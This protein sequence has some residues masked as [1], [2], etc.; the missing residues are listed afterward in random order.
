MYVH[1]FQYHRLLPV[2]AFNPHQ[3]PTVQE[4]SQPHSPKF[5]RFY[6]S[7]WAGTYFWNAPNNTH[8]SSELIYIHNENNAQIMNLSSYVTWNIIGHPL[9]LSP[10][11]SWLQVYYDFDLS[12]STVCTVSS[13]VIHFCVTSSFVWLMCEA[14][15][16]V[17]MVTKLKSSCIG[18]GCCLFVLSWSECSARGEYVV[19]VHMYVC[20]LYHVCISTYVCM[21]NCVQLGWVWGV[22][23]THLGCK[24][25]CTHTHAHAHT[26]AR[27]HTQTL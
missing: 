23:S 3:V 10:L 20:I 17:A 18:C 6:G 19:L 21:H 8:S 1:D 2:C 5:G 13:A 15:L 14:I 9:P 12:P 4:N 26:H 27:T 24:Y 7:Q 22:L 11:S 16:L 25:A